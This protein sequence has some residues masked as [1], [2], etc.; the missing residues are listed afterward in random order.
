MNPAA[1]NDADELAGDLGENSDH[2]SSFEGH[3][4]GKCAT[5]EH[6]VL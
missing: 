5:G 6:Q 4:K 1:F 3:H 2:N